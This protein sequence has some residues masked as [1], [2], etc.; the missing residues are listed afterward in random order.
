[1]LIYAGNHL[2]AM[3]AGL[4][5]HPF[6]RLVVALVLGVFLGTIWPTVSPVYLYGFALVG[7]CG[8]AMAV[9][10]RFAIQPFWKS[11]VVLL[12]TKS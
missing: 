3:Y 9:I 8:V 11:I 12:S 10:F 7:I 5:K 2:F 1:M 6:L 4:R